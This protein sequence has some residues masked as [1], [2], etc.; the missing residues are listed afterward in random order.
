MNR[1]NDIQIGVLQLNPHLGA[2]EDNAFHI[3]EGY[4]NLLAQ[5]ADLI[6][7]PE[8]S[9]T[10]YP[11]D[12][13]I[14]DP[15]FIERTKDAVLELAQHVQSPPLLVGA[16]WEVDGKIYN[17]VLKLENGTIEPV[18][19]KLDLPDYGPF[20]EKRTFTAGPTLPPLEI[21]GTKIGLLICEDG[22][23]LNKAAILKEKG[24]DAF[25]SLNASPYT[26]TKKTERLEVCQNLVTHFDT[27]LLYVNQIGGQDELIF[28]GAS[29]L[30]NEH[31]DIINAAKSMV[32]DSQLWTLG[33][34]ME[35][36]EKTVPP[37]ISY[38]NNVNLE[39]LY[40]SLVLSLRDYTHKNGFTQTI[41]G[42]SGGID[43]ALVAVLAADALGPENV[44]TMMLSTQYTS[45]TSLD[46]AREL[47]EDLVG[48][49][50]ASL[51]IQE[52]FDATRHELLKLVGTFK[53]PVTEENIQ[54]RLRMIFNLAVSNDESLLVLNTSNK[55]EYATGHST[56]YGDTSGGFAP[57][58][59][60]YKTSVIA[61]CKWRNENHHPMFKGPKGRVVPEMI[62]TRTPTPELNDS[63]TDDDLLPPYPILDGIIANLVEYKEKPEAL[64]KL[65]DEATVYD[66]AEK[67]RKQQFKR[68][69]SPLGP[70]V[71]KSSLGMRDRRIP[72]TNGFILKKGKSRFTA[73]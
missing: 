48:C 12:D 47:A 31:G 32:E 65:F 37:M 13:L 27:P 41:H 28:D 45:Q 64:I 63:Q 69:Q 24:A 11:A 61:L 55:S 54:A 16:P 19:Y 2:V 53:K 22:W 60:V 38:I 67:I 66:I 50:Y 17:A 70:I 9:I 23:S 18:S 5:K 68:R 20:N 26:V 39:D 33:S 1:F 73:G 35:A 72:V 58:V 3:L 36:L 42:L 29:F 44:K 10:G 21:K 8:L 56:L 59:D 4:K 43:S 6:V 52:S 25:I 62:I 49:H 34:R 15:Y 46:V 71:T 30:M 57:I 51:S 7:T 14:L 40:C